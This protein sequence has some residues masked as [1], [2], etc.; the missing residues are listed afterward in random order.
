M[1]FEDNKAP[2]KEA[3][4]FFLNKYTYR[5]RLDIGITVRCSPENKYGTEYLKKFSTENIPDNS[6]FSFLKKP[7]SGI[8]TDNHLLSLFVYGYAVEKKM[9]K[10]EE[11]TLSCTGLVYTNNFNEKYYN[12][13]PKESLNFSFLELAIIAMLREYKLDQAANEMQSQYNHLLPI[14]PQNYKEYPSLQ[15]ALR[16]VICR[17]LTANAAKE[18]SII[19]E[20]VLSKKRYFPKLLSTSLGKE[21][22]YELSEY[23]MDLDML[24]FLDREKRIVD[25]SAEVTCD[26]FNIIITEQKN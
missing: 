10:L 11:M 13:R 17:E 8:P 6:S 7:F 20:S 26:R 2:M 22:A 23:K 19:E 25:D 15:E 3:L 9:T 1:E 24:I 5:I 4:N 21:I 14:M 12:Q 16:K 18:E